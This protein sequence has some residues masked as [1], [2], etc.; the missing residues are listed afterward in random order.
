MI[1][2]GQFQRLKSEWFV[3]AR[4]DC[5]DRQVGSIGMENVAGAFLVMAGGVAGVNPG[6][7]ATH[8]L[9]TLTS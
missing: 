3:T 1:E 5:G 4:A 2:T 6:V 8:I 9:S 7:G